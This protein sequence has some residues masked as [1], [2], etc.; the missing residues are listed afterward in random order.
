M[1]TS[2]HNVEFI[3]SDTWYKWDYNPLLSKTEHTS[4]SK[5]YWV[6][7]IP[8]SNLEYVGI[9]I[10]SFFEISSCVSSFNILAFLILFSRSSFNIT[11]AFLIKV[12][13]NIIGIY[14]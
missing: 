7:V 6:F 13:I 2:N 12:P 8:L 3:K 10:F 9:E 4:I 5:V 1:K 14:T 11:Y